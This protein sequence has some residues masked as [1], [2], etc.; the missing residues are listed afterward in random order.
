MI[1]VGIFSFTVGQIREIRNAATQ[2]Y[3][4]YG[5]EKKLK[6]SGMLLPCFLRNSAV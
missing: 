4:H 3:S 1:K 5:I 2:K 6:I